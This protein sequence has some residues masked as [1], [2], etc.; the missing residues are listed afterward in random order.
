M[1]MTRTERVLFPLLHRVRTFRVLLPDKIARRVAFALPPRVVYHAAI[2]LVAHASSGKYGATEVPK[3]PAM[4]AIQ[5]Y[6]TDF[7]LNEYVKRDREYRRR[8]AT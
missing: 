6:E 2:R 8:S 5:R 3:L 1:T 7:D 4:R